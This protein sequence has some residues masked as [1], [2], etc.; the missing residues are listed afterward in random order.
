MSRTKALPVI[1]LLSGAAL[2]LSACSGSGGGGDATSGDGSI[3]EMA[4]PRGE[5]GDTY[6]A[7]ETKESDLIEVSQDK[8]FTTYNNATADGNNSYNTYALALIQ[9]GA[10]KLDGNNKVILN[11]DVMESVEVTNADPQEVTWKLKSGVK[12][13]D[14]EAWDCDDFYMQWFTSSG[15]VKKPDG[16]PYFLSA[17]SNGYELIDGS[18][19]DDQTFVGKF[20]DKYPDYQDLFSADV[21]PAHI[22]EK[23]ANVPDITKLTATSDAA[24]LA[25]VAEF[26][27]TKWNGFDKAI[28]PGS[29]PYVMTEFVANQSVTLERNPNWVGKKGGPKKI[30]IKAIPDPVAQAQALENNEV[31]VNGLTQPD[32]NAATRLKGLASQGITFGAAPGLSFEHLDLNF[33]HPALKQKE[34][35]Q[36][37]FQCV[38]RQDIADKLIAEIQSDV[39]PLGSLIFFPSDEGY[40]DLYADKSKGSADEAKKVLSGAG[41]TQGADGIFAKDGVKASFKISHTDIP[42]RKQTVELIQGHCKEAGIEVIDDTDPNFLDKRVS[43]GDYEVALFAW[44]GGPYKSSKKSIYET[45]GGQNWQGVSSKGYDEN[46]K[47]AVSQTSISDALKYYQEADKALADEYASLPLF[48]M[49]NMWAFKGID[50]VYFQSQYGVA[51]YANEWQLK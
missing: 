24:Q 25:A 38:K 49:P 42:R 23:Q 46:F 19:K 41:W 50:R 9:V 20:S 7:P 36:A 37:F 31:K 5:S 29:G 18:C 6:T 2:V 27:N 48:Q 47:K 34:V 21:L 43:D 1:A 39:K 13:S 15:K 11:K 14:G 10:Y 28:Q 51:T 8:P 3:A 30:F 45:G 32:V 22:V 16:S 12:W 35:R 4:V 40:K 17:S 33:K 26:W 44:S